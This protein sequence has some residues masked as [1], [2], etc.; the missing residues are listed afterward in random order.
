MWIKLKPVS[1]FDDD[2]TV[3]EEIDEMINRDITEDFKKSITT[4]DSQD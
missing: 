1:G 3:E 4:V 2:R